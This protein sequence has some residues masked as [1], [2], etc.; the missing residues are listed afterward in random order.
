[1]KPLE[2][3]ND[4]DPLD[5]AI[6]GEV[7]R[8]LALERLDRPAF[9][10]VFAS[11]G[12]PLEELPEPALWEGEL[13]R[14]THSE[15]SLTRLYALELKRRTEE[16][17]PLTLSALSKRAPGLAGYVEAWWEHQKALWRSQMH[18]YE[19]RTRRLFN[20][21]ALAR[22]PLA[23]NDLA[24]LL[25]TDPGSVRDHLQAVRGAFQP[26]SDAGI[27]LYRPALAG[28]HDVV[29]LGE[30]PR[31][32]HECFAGWGRSVISELKTGEL[33]A[34]DVP[35]YLPDA[36][37]HHLSEAKV[38][39]DAWDD[40][41]SEP[42]IDASFYVTGSYDAVL[43]DIAMAWEAVV[44]AMDKD[45]GADTRSELAHRV[46]RAL[47]YASVIARDVVVPPTL[48]AHAAEASEWSLSRVLAYCCDRPTKYQVRDPSAVDRLARALMPYGSQA[49]TRLAEGPDENLCAEVLQSWATQ[50]RAP[51]AAKQFFDSLPATMDRQRTNRLIGALASHL[52]PELLSQAFAIAEAEEHAYR[53]AELLELLAPHLPMELLER[54]FVIAGVEKDEDSRTTLH[55]KLAP[56]MPPE[57]L[58][59]AFAI[60]EAEEDEP[61]RTVLLISLVPAPAAGALGAGVRY[62]GG[63]RARVSLATSCCADAAPAAGARGA[64]DRH[65]GGGSGRVCSHLTSPGAGTAPAAGAADAGVRYSGDRN[66]RGISQGISRSARTAPAAG[67]PGAKNRHRGC[68]SGRV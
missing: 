23:L 58:A 59:R 41:L 27:A 37:R 19:E 62:H 8:P 61:Y 24:T 16:N 34:A 48:V 15:P 1:M 39:V 60:A 3:A 42:W 47:E 32:V 2:S 54:A 31:A 57:L 29:L 22:G 64:G 40:L 28:R 38:T 20:L 10:E 67:V 56:H 12:Q 26:N 25:D 7:V 5:G 14:L 6:A 50:C 49:L 68:K 9:L 43:A 63:P 33:S 65:R 13:L 4:A 46:E 66:G 52:P 44:A 45:D 30:S 51:E 36:L 11:M 18:A 17:A 55:R 21:L 35:R 53:R